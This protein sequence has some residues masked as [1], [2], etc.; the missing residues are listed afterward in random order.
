MAVSMPSYFM[1]NLKNMDSTYKQI[2]WDTMSEDE[3]SAASAEWR[4]LYNASG[5][6]SAGSTGSSAGPTTISSSGPADRFQRAS[7]QLDLDKDATYSAAPTATALSGFNSLLSGLSTSGLI[8]AGLEKNDA[9]TDAA[10]Q[11]R[12]TA[13]YNVMIGRFGGGQGVLGYDVNG[14]GAINGQNELFGNARTAGSVD[15]HVDFSRID[16]TSSVSF[17]LEGEADPQTFTMTTQRNVADLA[18]AI[19]LAVQARDLHG[20]AASV[21]DGKLRIAALDSSKDITSGRLSQTNGE[22][23]GSLN[24]QSGMLDVN[25]FFTVDADGNA[26]LDTAGGRSAAALMLLASNG[27]STRIDQSASGL[28]NGV[29]TTIT[30]ALVLK[31][32][33]GAR[34]NISI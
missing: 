7:N 22:F 12:A 24:L 18:A 4:S 14:D 2:V 29:D 15:F 8:F 19:N 10:T 30:A 11:A 31:R 26:T 5:S 13:A 33:Q 28:V 27:G 32:N 21:V 9:S 34:I 20:V 17:T 23:A 16:A 25:E 6:P 1:F 3:Q